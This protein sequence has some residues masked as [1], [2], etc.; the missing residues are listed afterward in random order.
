MN[1]NRQPENYLENFT[2]FTIKKAFFNK[3]GFLFQVLVICLQSL[4]NI[5]FC[6][7]L[8]IQS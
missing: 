4:A 6:R 1:E 7:S 2:Q 3:E 8:P 5:G